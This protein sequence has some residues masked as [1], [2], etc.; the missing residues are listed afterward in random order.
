[1]LSKSPDLSPLIR[2]LGS[3]VPLTKAQVEAVM[4]LPANLRQIGAGQEV[5]R[6]GDQPTQACLVLDGLLCRFKVAAEGARQI[7]SYHIPGDIPDL[8]SLHLPKMDH[9]IGAL[10]ASTLAMIPHS[11]LR[12]LIRRKPDLAHLLWRE[13]LVDGSVFREWISNIGRRPAL[14][15]LAHV[16]CELAV[17]Y[18]VLGLLANDLTL[19]GRIKQAD[20]G[21]AL[22]LSVVHVNR[23]FKELKAR[24]LIRTKGPQIRI[25]D[26]EGL[27]D[28]GD[29]DPA[30][31]HLH[32]LP[33]LV[34]SRG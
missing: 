6:E 12:E 17:R 25:L 19:P 27:M 21:D 1:M 24:R 18:D 33:R 7:H 11:A 23:V 34:A 20:I 5:V 8:Q 26:F 13:T 2:K 32:T 29:F 31:L 22:G 30:Y 4:A 28:I 10:R 3:E 16:L 14:A 15:R 9:S